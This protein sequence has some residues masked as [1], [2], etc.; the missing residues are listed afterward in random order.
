MSSLTLVVSLGL[1][2]VVDVSTAGDTSVAVVV[3]VSGVV[4]RVV[5]IA[6]VGNTPH[7]RATLTQH[8]Q[9]RRCR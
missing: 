5:Y 9:Q 6:A 7:V 4:G 3:V 2:L 8:N 1:L